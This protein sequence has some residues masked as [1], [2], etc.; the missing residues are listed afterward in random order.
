MRRPAILGMLGL[1]LTVTVLLANL[2]PAVGHVSAVSA[3]AL[4]IP[5]AAPENDQSD[6]E[7]ARLTTEIVAALNARSFPEF[8]PAIT[9]LGLANLRD[10]WRND[11][12]T[13]IFNESQASECS[14]GDPAS[15]R[16][17]VVIG[18]SYAMAWMPGLRKTLLEANYRITQL[19]LGHCPTWNLSVMMDGVNFTECDE[20][21]AWV[22]SYL[23]EHQPSLVALSSAAYLADSLS[24]EN[25][26]PRCSRRFQMASRAVIASA[27]ASEARVF[28]LGSPPGSENLR[29]MRETRRN[30]GQLL[31]TISG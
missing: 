4:P 20:Q 27:Q 1:L 7:Q 31:G 28:V 21:H 26:A 25:T 18:D 19:T 2:T 23:T 30:A 15:P 29:D 12:C 14:V 13:D 16:T 22:Q 10:Q 8:E 5:I 9:S 17:A 6:P 11:G 3:A 24:S